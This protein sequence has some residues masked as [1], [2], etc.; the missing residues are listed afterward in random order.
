MKDLYSKI[1]SKMALFQS[2]AKLAVEKGN[3]AAAKRS[4]AYSLELADLLKEWRRISVS[5]TKKEE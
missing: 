2:E 1:A 3:K 4:R 5:Q